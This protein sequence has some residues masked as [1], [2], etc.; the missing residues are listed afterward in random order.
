MINKE[1]YIRRQLKLDK[2]QD[3]YVDIFC[4]IEEPGTDGHYSCAYCINGLSKTL[5]SFG[6]GIDAVQALYITLQL[7]GNRLSSTEEFKSG[8]LTWVGSIDGKDLG[9]PTASG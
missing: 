8:R 6:M 5:A 2:E 7:I 9:F 4:P 1:P 3:V